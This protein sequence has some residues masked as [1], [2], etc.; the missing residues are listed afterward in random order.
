MTNEFYNE[1]YDNF[2]ND[3]TIRNAYSDTDIDFK[4]NTIKADRMFYDTEDKFLYKNRTK[5]L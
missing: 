1:D 3:A 5:D 2:G 4:N